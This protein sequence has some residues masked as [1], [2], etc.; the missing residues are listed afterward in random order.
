MSD[1]FIGFRTEI[2]AKY[3]WRIRSYIQG[4]SYPVFIAAKES[5][6]IMPFCSRRR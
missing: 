2:T 5:S 4:T 6:D 1:V 3:K